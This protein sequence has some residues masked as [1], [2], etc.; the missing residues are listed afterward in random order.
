M[1]G[2]I[3]VSALGYS[4]ETGCNKD[5]HVFVYLFIYLGHILP[6]D[7]REASDL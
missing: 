7:P 3:F 2:D 5:W 4:W 1:G 6:K